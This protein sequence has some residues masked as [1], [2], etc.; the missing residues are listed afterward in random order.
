MLSLNTIKVQCKDGLKVVLQN[1]N[2]IGIGKNILNKQIYVLKMACG[3][4]WSHFY[5]RHCATG[6]LVPQSKEYEHRV[7]TN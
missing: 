6:L 5:A 3:R 1:S 2:Y 7:K 4:P